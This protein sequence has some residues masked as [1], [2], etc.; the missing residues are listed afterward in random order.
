M[1]YMSH[2]P[3]IGGFTLAAMNVF[4]GS[5]KVITSYSPFI[6]NDSLLLDYLEKKNI[7]VPYIQLDKET[8]DFSHL[9]KNMDVVTAIPPC[10]ILSASSSFKKGKRQT[11][12]EN[13][14]MYK[15]AD[16][17]LGEV[18]PTV[19]VFENAPNLYTDNG[20]EIR[21][22]LIHTAKYFNYAVTFY[23]TDTLLHGIPQKRPRT[24]VIFLKGNHAPILHSIRRDSPSVEKYLKS[25]PKDATLQN[26]FMCCESSISDYEIVKFLKLKY[27]SSWRNQVLEERFHMTSYDFLKRRKLLYEY[28]EFLKTLDNVHPNSKKDIEHVIKK[29]EMGKNFRLSHRVLCLDEHHIYAVIGEMMERNIHPSEDR[30]MN[31]REYLTLMSMP[32]DFDMPDDPR[33]YAKLTQNVPVKTSED[34]L[35]EIKEV[36]NGNRFFYTEKVLM[37]D[38]TKK[39]LIPAKSK[40]LF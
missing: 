19:Y 37:I 33:Q 34:I 32:F 38:N 30:R 7:D 13:N 10:N 35:E 26:S 31:I 12:F 21:E 27:G 1:N 6:N 4:G 29:T 17:I 28:R 20:I 2:I 18:K 25:I 40:K 22:N 3:L 5:P 24:Y 23:K 15:S 8:K 11:L 39:F 14:W 36:L 9:Y 16:F